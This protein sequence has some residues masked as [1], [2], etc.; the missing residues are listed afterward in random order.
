[1]A[2]ALFAGDVFTA[3]TKFLDDRNFFSVIHMHPTPDFKAGAVTA[4]AIFVFQI[5]RANPGTG[6]GNGFLLGRNHDFMIHFL[7]FLIGQDFFKGVEGE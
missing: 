4:D 2:V 1:V 7:F 3:F 6:R 5:H